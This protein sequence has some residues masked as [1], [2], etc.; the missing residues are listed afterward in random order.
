MNTQTKTTTEVIKERLNASIT[1]FESSQTA[2]GECLNLQL[3]IAVLSWGLGATNLEIR[4]KRDIVKNR[5]L[6]DNSRGVSAKDLQGSFSELE[7]L[8]TLVGI[9]NADLLE[10]N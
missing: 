5:I 1:L 4:T 7:A 10:R 2:K 8:E 6:T 3:K 9:T